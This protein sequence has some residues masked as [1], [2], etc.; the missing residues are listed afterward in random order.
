MFQIVE[1]FLFIDLSDHEN[2]FLKLD[3]FVYF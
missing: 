3:L 1:S 2:D